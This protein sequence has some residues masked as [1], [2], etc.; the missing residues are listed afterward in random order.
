MRRGSIILNTGVPLSVTLHD[1]IF[2]QLALWQQ[3]FLMLY[4]LTITHS[5]CGAVSV[6]DGHHKAW[7]FAYSASPAAWRAWYLGDTHQTFSV[8][9]I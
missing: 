3:N 1:E 8:R 7:R 4:G 2:P 6:T 9:K 5:S